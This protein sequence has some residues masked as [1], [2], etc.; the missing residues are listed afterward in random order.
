MFIVNLHTMK[1]L[2]VLFFLSL[3]LTSVVNAQDYKKFKLGLGL[4]FAAQGGNGGELVTIESA[5]RVSDKLA[6]GLRFEGVFAVGV[7]DFGEM[8]SYTINGQYYL[9][10]DKFRP[11]VGAGLG[12]YTLARSASRF[13]FY[14]RA[15]FDS[16]HFT[17]A[18]EYNLI[19]AS[20]IESSTAPNSGATVTNSY[21]GIR[22]GGFLFGGKK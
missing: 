9:S 11:F 15:G 20:T 16:G 2:C 22:I 12:I 19:P 3:V 14:P 8:G 4:G 21:L 13:G 7:E 5:Y 18:L 17:L 10:A 1:K 6:V